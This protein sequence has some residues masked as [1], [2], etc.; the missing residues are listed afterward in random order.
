MP[1]GWW[2][3]GGHLDRPRATCEACYVSRSLN[4]IFRSSWPGWWW[5]TVSTVGD[6]LMYNLYS[7]LWRHSSTLLNYKDFESTRVSRTYTPR[8]MSDAAAASSRPPS[9]LPD[10]PEEERTNTHA[11]L[12]PHQ[13]LFASQILEIL[14]RHYESYGR[15]AHWAPIR[16]FGRVIIVWHEVDDAESAKRYGDYLHLDVDLP[17]ASD[18][19]ERRLG[20]SSSPR[21]SAVSAPEIHG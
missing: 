10:L 6:E 4:D 9:L 20:T 16:A 11:L 12:L 17:A 5:S 3:A 13:A 8:K 7:A 21:R 14:R 19:A 18:R 15:I 1:T 2:L